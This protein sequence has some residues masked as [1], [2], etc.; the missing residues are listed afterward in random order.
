MEEEKGRRRHGSQSAQPNPGPATRPS[1]SRP[2]KHGKESEDNS[3][4]EFD[5]I[6]L[7]IMPGAEPEIADDGVDVSAG[8]PSFGQVVNFMLPTLG[9]L[10]ANPILSMVDTS[11]VGRYNDKMALG[12]LAPSTAA[13]DQAVYLASFISVAT[14]MPL[15]PL[16]LSLSLSLL[17]AT[18]FRES[19]LNIDWLPLIFDMETPS[20]SLVFYA[21]G[22]ETHQTAKPLTPRKILT[23]VR[24]PLADQPVC[25][26]NGKKGHIWCSQGR[27]FHSHP[28]RLPGHNPWIHPG[29]RGGVSHAPPRWGGQQGC[30]P[31]RAQG[32]YRH[33]SC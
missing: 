27:C 33:P 24:T 28:R 2:L 20:Q 22:Q 18:P 29:I 1:V 19:W 32:E 31:T 11:F 4:E 23:C 9:M 13:C 17:S 3:D 6:G 26:C 15:S 5:Q 7:Q 12:A 16:S 10:L 30:D 21:R 25:G 14:V 8:P